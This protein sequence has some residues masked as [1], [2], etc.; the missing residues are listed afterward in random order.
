MSGAGDLVVE[1]VR[2][3]RHPE[4]MREERVDVLELPLDRVQT[5]GVQ[6]AHHRSLIGR[7]L[8]LGAM[9][10]RVAELVA[11]AHEDQSPG[12]ARGRPFELCAL[13]QRARQQRAIG[14][15]RPT[16]RDRE[17]CDVVRLG[18]VALVVLTLGRLGHRAEDLHRDVSAPESRHVG[19]PAPRGTHHAAVPQQQ[20]VVQVGDRER[21][22]QVARTLGDRDRRLAVEPVHRPI[23][24]HRHGEEEAR[25]ER[26]PHTGGERNAANADHGRG[27][28]SGCLL[29]A[30]G[31]STLQASVAICQ[32]PETLYMVNASTPQCDQAPLM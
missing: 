28:P 1:E 26:E 4:P 5:L 18:A 25:E 22:V 31:C 13:M 10:Q 29:H 21:G 14:A 19:L 8:P 20:V 15:G 11:A 6:E 2:Q 7:A 27:A 24:V 30:G 9:R 12:G 17:Q 32:R 16:R 3:S 23:D